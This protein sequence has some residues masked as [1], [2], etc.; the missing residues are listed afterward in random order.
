[1]NQS[2]GKCGLLLGLV[3]VLVMATGFQA[4]AQY[5]KLYRF[6]N[7]A[8]TQNSV[9]AIM[10]GFE[11]SGGLQYAYPAGWK[12]ASWG[13]LLFGGYFSTG[14][15]F[16]GSAVGNGT[17]VTIGWR[18]AD[19]NCY[20][21]DLRWGTGVAVMPAVLGG[22]PGGA[23]VT[24]DPVTGEATVTIT[25]ET[26]DTIYLEGTDFGVVAGELSLDGLADLDLVALR[27]A[28]ID[29]LI[30]A[31]VALIDQAA[32]AGGVGLPAV[33]S[34][35]TKLENAAQKK[36]EG[37]VAW[38]AGNEKR[39][40]FLWG[41]A[42]QQVGNVISE[43]ERSAAKGDLREYL[44]GIWKPL[45]EE[46]IAALLALPD[47][48]GSPV[49]GV[50]L[51]PG[52]SFT[53]VIPNVTDG[54]GLVLCGTVFDLDGNPVLDWVEQGVA[55]EWVP[56]TEPPVILSA[57]ITP[58][59]LWPP[60]HE[61]IPM[62]VDVEFADPEDDAVWYIESV[63]SNQPE[64]GTGDGDD[65][66]DSVLDPDDVQSLELRAERSG[67]DPTET[68]IYTVI[69][70]AIDMAGNESDP[71]DLPV[72]VEHDVG[73]V[74]P[75]QVTSLAAVPTTGRGVQIVFTLA[76]SSQVE[77]EVFNIAGRPIKTIVRDR[78]CPKGT[79]SLVWNCSSDRGLPVP[80]GTYLIRLT[81]RTADGQQGSR[82]CPVTVQR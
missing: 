37:L 24:W 38:Y 54:A 22:V 20:M 35:T 8:G 49:E 80:A 79:N 58:G 1:M 66:P 73:N 57:S 70:K 33:G 78:Q 69:L 50:V 3:L 41:K 46:I 64:D 82:L 31:L 2:V 10:H 19:Y 61:M 40:L 16:G 44:L 23:E 17:V 45:A 28:A 11:V 62:A 77:A 52:E 25:N 6:T 63:S 43:M 51:A 60:N 34:L 72:R 47:G 76:A 26:D 12:P 9:R 5:S 30:D 13:Y 71:Y 18:T 55:E 15:T 7:T 74:G 21:R 53:F 68:R 48:V 27:V 4:Q 65:A 75:A 59:F 32:A 81:A 36:E 39:A 14:V 42:A 67:N 29:A 56:D